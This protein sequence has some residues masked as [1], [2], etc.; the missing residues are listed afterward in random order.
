MWRCVAASLAITLSAC[1]SDPVR[2]EVPIVKPCLSAAP[3]EPVYSFGSGAYPGSDA[4]AAALLWGDFVAART[5]AE[6]LKLQ[7]AGCL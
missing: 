6:A 5:Y 4:E 2:V 1:A 7:H 3:A